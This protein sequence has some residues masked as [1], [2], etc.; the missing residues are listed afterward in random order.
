MRR[1][2]PALPRHGEARRVFQVRL[3]LENILASKELLG[4]TFQTTLTSCGL[5][6]S[7]LFTEEA[8]GKLFPKLGA[9]EHQLL[10][11]FQSFFFFFLF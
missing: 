2:D 9:R 3:F 6:P 1:Q 10:G 11:V 7:K 8:S 4:S 5:A